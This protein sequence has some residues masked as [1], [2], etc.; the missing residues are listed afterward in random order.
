MTLTFTLT[1]HASTP[2][3][4]DSQG[5]DRLL[6]TLTAD[7]GFLRCC[8]VVDGATDKSGRDYGGLSGGARAADRIVTTLQNLSADST[9]V[10][11]LDA[12]TGGLA[13]LRTE[14]GIAADDLLAPSAVVA[15]L[16]P[17]RRQIMRVGDVHIGIRRRNGA[18]EYFPAEK[19]IDGVVASARAALLHALRADGAD[20]ADLAR[21]DPGR[22]MMMPL[23]RVQNSLANRDG[24]PYG[25]G[26][27]D[28][29]PVPYRYLEII[30][31]DDTVTEIVLASDGYLSAAPTLEGAER[32]LAD[33]LTA[34]P[35]RIGLHASTKGIGSGASR[36]DDCT[37]AR[38]V[39]P[40]TDSRTA[41]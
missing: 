11:I 39:A 33:D 13:A 41:G 5:E 38:L 25:F 20:P 34:D 14:W 17:D 1:E 7:D 21:T 9:A 40:G 4:P 32:E 12:V 26:V 19:E 15:I 31:L 8:A 36:F 37:Y 2:K 23:L 28:G 10:G 24:S 6:N 16:L 18:W 22:A 27:L 30:E 35:L 29:R 3:L